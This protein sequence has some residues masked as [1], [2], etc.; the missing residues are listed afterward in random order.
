[1][2]KL[3]L[4]YWPASYFFFSAQAQN[5]YFKSGMVMIVNQSK[6]SFVKGTT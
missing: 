3:I 5:E 2:K 1:M 4:A 6:A